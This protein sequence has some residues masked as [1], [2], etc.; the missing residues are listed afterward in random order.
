MQSSE[1]IQFP[2]SVFTFFLVYSYLWE[3]LKVNFHDLETIGKKEI[4]TIRLLKSH[5]PV[6]FAIDKL[7]FFSKEFTI[8]Y[9]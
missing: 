5:A 6:V 9:S 7:S 2:V 3:Y 1:M 8:L 4:F